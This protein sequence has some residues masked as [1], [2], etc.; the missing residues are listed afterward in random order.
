MLNI[1]LVD[2]DIEFSDVICHIVEFL[3]HNINTATSLKE[4]HQWFENNTFDH[5]LLDFMLPDGSGLHLLD[6]LKMIGQSP[7]VTLISGHPSVK[8]ILA[9]MCE[10]NVSHLLKPLQR[11]DLELVLNGPKKTVKK[12]KSA[13]I[14]HHF[15]TLIGESAPMQQLYTMIERVAKTNANVMLMGESGAGKEV[16]AQAIHNA[17]KCEGPLVASNCGALSK[18]L[19]GSELF[20]HEKGAFTGAIARK[21]G[22]FEQA[23]GGTLFLDEVTEMPIDMQPNLLRVLETKKVTRVG[24]NRELPVNCRVISATN[25]SLTDLAQNNI[26]REDIYFRL[27]VFPIDIPPLRERKEDIPLLS[28]VFLEQLNDE[29]GTAFAWANEQLKE[30]QTYDWP[31][32][33]RELRHAIHRAF[34]MSDPQT[35]TITLPDNLES[36]FSRVNTQSEDKQVSAGQTIEEVEKELIHATLDKVQGNKTLAAQMLGISTKTLYNR[37]NAYGG[38][39]EYK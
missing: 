35:S 21:E 29:N 36:P 25:R 39:G 37:L 23:D 8:G 26:L 2:D 33:V 27:A 34:I 38:I 3:G 18:E 1:L 22:V 7:K 14:T 16:V 11:E 17:S 6:H 5:V 10:P 4:A 12:A 31:G 13:A 9:E 30:L 32:N 20:G 28:K 15:D 19:I 24:G